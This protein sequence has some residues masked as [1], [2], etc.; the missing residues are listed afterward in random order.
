MVPGP[1]GGGLGIG[2]AGG[3]GTIPQ[4]PAGPRRAPLGV[5]GF[6]GACPGYG[7]R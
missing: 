6:G 1:P 7:P 5:C 4:A 3:P 2:W